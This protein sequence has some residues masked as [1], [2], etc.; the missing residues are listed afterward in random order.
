MGRNQD[1]PRRE[2]RFNRFRNSKQSCLVLLFV[3]KT[4]EIN[5]FSKIQKKKI[6]TKY[7]L[8]Q[9]APF[10]SL[11]VSFY[12]VLVSRLLVKTKFGPEIC[13]SRGN[14]GKFIFP[15]LPF[16]FFRRWRVSFQFFFWFN[17]E[18]SSSTFSVFTVSRGF[19]E[20]K[21]YPN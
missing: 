1:T 13:F 6:F 12:S 7:C 2:E 11:S 21:I 9:F 15:S 20:V 16:F 14:K 19:G 4:R 10:F 8:F 5:P 18:I 3:F 17:Y